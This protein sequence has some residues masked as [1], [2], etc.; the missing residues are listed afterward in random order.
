MASK[1]QHPGPPSEYFSSSSSKDVEEKRFNPHP[2][3]EID[4]EEKGQ[5]D[6]R[7]PIGAYFAIP[8]A[9]RT[10]NLFLSPKPELV[11]PL[12]ISASIKKTK[13]L[14]EPAEKAAWKSLA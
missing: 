9:L 6:L 12:L 3:R 13:I 2:S 8:A 11:A 10:A 4:R 7:L 5:M 1:R 14:A